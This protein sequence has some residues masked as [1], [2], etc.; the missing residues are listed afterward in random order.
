MQTEEL[1]ILIGKYLDESISPAEK[2]RLALL[3]E[4]T[5]HADQFRELL[6]TQMKSRA[7]EL[8]PDERI[9]A[10]IRKQVQ[11]KMSET[12]FANNEIIENQPQPVIRLSTSRKWWWAAASVL[13]LVVSITYFN[14]GNK[15][16][17]T[18]AI[19]PVAEIPAGSE[20]AILTLADGSQVVLDSVK[21]GLIAK[22]N[23]AEVLLSNG[24]MTYRPQE[25]AD[26]KIAYNT[27]STPKGRQ[28]QFTLPDG[29]MVWL[30]AASSIRF[31]TT[32]KSGKG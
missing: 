22:Q 29:T 17:S 6:S 12:D 7:L 25:T 23:G 9:G 18:P 27:M 31:P 10:D 19:V 32:L 1:N 15:E 30:N 24:T 13:V 28:F 5:T 20:G 8:E 14:N 16:N 3:L 4:D 26:S 11:A 21:N 2:T